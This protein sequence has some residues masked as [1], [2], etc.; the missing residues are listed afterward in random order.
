VRFSLL[1]LVLLSGCRPPA[2]DENGCRPSEKDA[3]EVGIDENKDGICDRSTADWSASASVP[4]SGNRADIYNLGPA[5]DGVRARGV[6]HFLS[7]PVSVSGVLLPNR[8]MQALLDPNTT[9]QDTKNLQGAARNVLGFGTTPE[10]YT[11]LGL[12][13]R[14][15][16]AEAQLG[17]PW[18]SWVKEGDYLGVGTVNTPQGEAMT[19]SCATCHAGNLFGRTVVGMTN[20]K[21][22]ANEF[23]HKA[24]GFFP[25]LDR[26][27]FVDTMGA[28]PE[29]LERFLITQKHLGAVGS[30]TPAVQGLDT[31]LAQVSLSLARRADDANAT[32]DP[33]IEASPRENLLSSYISDSKPAVWWNVK[34]KTRWLS[35][36]SIVEGNPIFTNFLWNEIGRGTDLDVLQD[37]LK[38]NQNIV[39]ELTVMVFATQAPK[40]VDFF[41]ADSIDEESAKRGEQKFNAMCS[42]CHGTYEKDWSAATKEARLATT[43]VRYHAQ[44]PVM[45]V[46]TSPQRAHG[47][48]AFADALNKLTVSQWM[49]T[50][51]EV[52][53]GYVPPPLEGIW[54]RYPYLHNQSVPT[55]C[56][57]L[58]PASA[59]TPVFYMGDDANPATDYDSTCVGLP[60]GDAVPAS[61]KIDAKRKYDTT[62]PG[63][64]NVGHDAWLKNENGQPVLTVDERADLI[65]YLKTL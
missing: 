22:Q 4:E 47:M 28:N 45:D 6:E 41:G 59:R 58:G 17:V 53:T 62:I 24:A 15:A 9:S 50:K 13:Q 16:N 29:E 1:S 44:T 18:P 43:R 19:F 39:D 49:K 25:L 56:E 61:W 54:A 55:L 48:T 46:G 35:D 2:C 5:L 32:R 38:Q 20:R 12:P 37:W 31:S 7:W 23:F 21:E 26:D 51:V 52:Q 63:L 11:Y 8:P 36:G 10:M 60:V 57:L 30:K 3:C 65:A 14:D 33:A 27:I 40:W 42:S 34:Y 64:S